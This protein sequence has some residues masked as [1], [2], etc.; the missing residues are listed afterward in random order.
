MNRSILALPLA[1][2]CLLPASRLPAQAAK[3]GAGPARPAVSTRDVLAAIDAHLKAAP[4][5]DREHLRFFTLANLHNNPAVTDADLRLYRTA[6]SAA[7]A[8][9]SR[10]GAVAPGAVDRAK[11]VFA[12]DV[13]KL[14]WDSERDW[15]TIL[16]AYPY[17]LGYAGALVPALAPLAALEREITKLSRTEIPAVRADWFV[18]TATRPP[19]AAKLKGK[20]PG[21]FP[22]A[23]ETLAARHRADLTLANAAYELGLDRPQTLADAV[24][25]SRRLRALGLAPLLRGGTIKRQDWEQIGAT[26]LFQRVARELEVGVPIMVVK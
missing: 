22:R 5:A 4:A 15:R 23:V 20:A 24:K 3:K 12:V 17:G 16:R 1:L 10:K 26:S 18:A 21:A 9:L 11:T 7:L 19:L 2:A 25:D 6:L 8:G 14:G 13:R